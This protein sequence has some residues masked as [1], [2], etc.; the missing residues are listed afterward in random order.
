ML[1]IQLRWFIS[2]DRASNWQANSRSNSLCVISLGSARLGSVWFGLVWFDL[3][4]QQ[5]V[6]PD[7]FASRLNQ[8]SLAA[9]SLVFAASFRMTNKWLPPTSGCDAKTRPWLS[10]NKATSSPFV[11][12]RAWSLEVKHRAKDS[13]TCVWQMSPNG[14]RKTT[15][16]HK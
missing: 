12:S 14:E 15:T 5:S 2:I 6:L 10:L 3:A 16:K 4:K 1:S 7:D 9:T 13:Q 11:L 8:S